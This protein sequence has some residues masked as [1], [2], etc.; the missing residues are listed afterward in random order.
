M[1]PT[2]QA[3]AAN[4]TAEVAAEAV[5]A[6][7]AAGPA[8]RQS[9]S[10]QELVCTFPNFYQKLGWI[11]SVQYSIYSMGPHKKRYCTVLCTVALLY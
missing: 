5:A 8:G 2:T 11:Q 9:E 1:S 4:P 6:A 7:A 3:H 10:F